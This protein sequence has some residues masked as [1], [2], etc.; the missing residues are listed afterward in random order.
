MYRIVP[1]K[2]P[3]PSKGPPPNF[4]SCVVY[5]VLRVTTHHAKFL[6]G[7]S[8]VHSLSSRRL[9]RW[10]QAPLH[11]AAHTGRSLVRSVLRLQYE[12][13]ILQATNAGKAMAT[14]L[15]IGPFSSRVQLCLLPR[16]P[17]LPKKG[18]AG[19]AMTRVNSVA[20]VS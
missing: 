17:L 9:F 8:K 19:E 20:P 15:C 16:W 12:I 11:P 7:D 6:R 2:H 10:F 3:S 4:D 18:S 1:C 13:C 14:R 5:E